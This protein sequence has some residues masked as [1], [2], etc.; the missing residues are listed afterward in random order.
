MQLQFSRRRRAID[1]LP[2]TDK[3]DADTFELFKQGH[4]MSEIAAQSI[5]TPAD[6]HV[7]PAALGIH[8]ELAESRPLVL[9]PTDPLVHI[10]GRGPAPCVDVV[11]QLL[12]LVL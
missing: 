2:E 12:Q 1:T 9:C 5:E 7:E 6:Q 11:A 10:L 8:D 3:R 4:E